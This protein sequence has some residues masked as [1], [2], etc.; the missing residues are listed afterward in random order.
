MKTAEDRLDVLKKKYLGMI[1]TKQAEIQVIRQKLALLDELKAEADD[2]LE[3]FGIP[4]VAT[5]SE[6][7]PDHPFAATGLTESVMKSLSWFGT[8]HFTPPEMRE[9]LLKN[10]F[11]PSGKNFS[12]SV[13]TT[14]KRLAAREKILSETLN[15]KTVY[16]AKP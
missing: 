3:L 9:V 1:D 14:L 7:L 16:R 12:I 5:K 6:A 2:G 10:G 4:T 8:R 13:G 11:K 15:G